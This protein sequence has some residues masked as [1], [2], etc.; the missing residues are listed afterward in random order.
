MPSRSDNVEE[1]ILKYLDDTISQSEMVTLNSI[2]KSDET[3]RALFIETTQQMGY[4]SESFYHQSDLDLTKNKSISLNQQLRSNWHWG[5][6]IAALFILLL[7]LWQPWKSLTHDRE[8]LAQSVGIIEEQRGSFVVVGNDGSYHNLSR[9][10]EPVVSGVLKSSSHDS[11]IK[12]RLNCGS[13]I[14]FIGKGA[15]GIFQ[16]ESKHLVLYHG[17]IVADIKN[18]TDANPL[19]VHTCLSELK[20]FQS[21]FYCSTFQGESFL[22]I[23]DGQATLSRRNTGESL[24][25]NPQ[26]S[27]TVSPFRTLSDGLKKKSDITLEF[28]ISSSPNKFQDNGDN[29]IVIPQF[30]GVEI[31]DAPEEPKGIVGNMEMINWPSQQAAIVDLIHVNV[32]SLADEKVLLDRQSHIQIA[33]KSIAPEWIE[34]VLYCRNIDSSEFHVLKH[35]FVSFSR[36]DF[37]DWS[38]SIS[39]LEFENEM[40]KLGNHFQSL[41]LVHSIV[42]TPKTS[43]EFKLNQFSVLNGE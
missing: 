23:L 16:S 10:H 14:E 13:T 40:S 43:L 21:S 36:Q 9:S 6:A 19:Y 31:P 27:L 38:L 24:D 42:Y 18:Q 41:E 33:S 11:Y 32:A 1:L 37:D 7:N 26:Q 30:H 25:L 34:I 17:S 39:I 35:K 22:E 15:L 2:L 3:A 20:T 29:P 5:A 8:L 28:Q 4:I 12:L